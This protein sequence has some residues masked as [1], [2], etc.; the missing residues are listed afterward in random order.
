MTKVAGMPELPI[1]AYVPASSRQ[2]PE[3]DRA[4]PDQV[5]RQIQQRD[6]YR[7]RNC[8]WS[9]EQW[10]Q[11][12]P[13]HLEAHHIAPHAKGGQNTTENLITLCNICQDEIHRK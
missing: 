7:C 10:N 12:D 13:R 6:E 9:Y 3:H 4:I 1:G 5:R 8:G 2:A 11:S